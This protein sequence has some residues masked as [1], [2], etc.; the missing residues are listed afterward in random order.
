MEEDRPLDD[1]ELV[2]EAGDEAL[3]P[4]ERRRLQPEELDGAEDVVDAGGRRLDGVHELGEEGAHR[5]LEA[6]QVAAL[7][8]QQLLEWTHEEP[9]GGGNK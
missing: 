3:R 4:Q 6:L 5:R 2:L 1:W 8:R 9:E 7:A